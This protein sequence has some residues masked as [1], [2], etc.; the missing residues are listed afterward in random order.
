MALAAAE[1]TFFA[2][3]Y[4]L[5]ES[6]SIQ[7]YIVG[8]V[9]FGVATLSPAWFAFCVRFTDCRI[10]IGKKFAIFTIVVALVMSVL[11]ATNPY[12]HWVWHWIERN[13]QP[14][15]EAWIAF[16][17]FTT[18]AYLLCG[19]GIVLLLQ[20]WAASTGVY[21]WQCAILL[22]AGIIP[23]VIDLIGQS[24]FVPF[25]TDDIT[26]LGFFASVILVW[27]G[28]LR[29]RLLDLAPVAH[30]ALLRCMQ[31]GM[32][33]VDDREQ[34]LERNQVA[35]AMLAELTE[36]SIGKPAAQVLPFWLQLRKECCGGGESRQIELTLPRNP[37][38][39]HLE[40]RLNPLLDP[41]GQ[42]QGCLLIFRDVTEHRRIERER[43]KL[44]SELQ[45][46]MDEVKTLSGLLPICSSCKKIRDDSG[47]WHSIESYLTKNTEAQLTHGFCPECI[48]RLYPKYTPS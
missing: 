47:E 40:V 4:F 11:V 28:L 27:W 48:K 24:R 30:E 1:W 19:A 14:K 43:E 37:N 29:F 36:D 21:R 42:I 18:Y 45:T 2:G 13:G 6:P 46:A 8:I 35:A 26:P 23:V 5:I 10:Q 31:D 39:L 7:V 38:S 33:V 12:H 15:S 25:L 41:R 17:I 3:T 20:K 22:A 16:W 34:I 9:Y 32:L 44:V